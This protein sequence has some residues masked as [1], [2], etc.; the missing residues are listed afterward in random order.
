[1][2][3]TSGGLGWRSATVR[4]TGSPSQAPSAVT[5][6]RRPG[7]CSGKDA[8]AQLARRSRPIPTAKS[9]FGN[10]ENLERYAANW[11]AWWPKRPSGTAAL[12]WSTR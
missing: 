1:M 10:V 7:V 2:T 8:T 4:W 12:T 5:E 11:I 3:T 9:D 6:A